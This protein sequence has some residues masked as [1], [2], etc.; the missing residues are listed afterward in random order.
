MNIQDIKKLLTPFFVEQGF[1]GVNRNRI[2]IK[3]KGYYLIAAEIQPCHNIGF[4]LN[5]GVR[6]L[7]TRHDGISFDYTYEGLRVYGQEN[8]NMT[9]GAILY[10]SPEFDNEII[11]MKHG[12]QK[13]I[14]IY[15][16]FED[17]RFLEIMIEAQNNRGNLINND[18]LNRNIHLAIAYMLLDKKEKAV[19]ILE[20][21]AEQNSVARQLVVFCEDRECFY[22]ELLNIINEVRNRISEKLKINLSNITSI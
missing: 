1:V 22:K 12:I 3:D 14:E 4:F 7:W 6:F 8:S 15:E 11:H 2:F 17:I 9:L 21:A 13:K 18:F 5:I 19:T 20:R 10:D 16:K